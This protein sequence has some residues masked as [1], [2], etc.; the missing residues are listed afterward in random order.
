MF[1]FGLPHPVSPPTAPTDEN[2]IL[3]S[4]VVFETAKRLF[5]IT[6]CLFLMPLVA[7]LAAALLFLNPFLN[8]GPLL[9]AQERM[10]KNCKPFRVLKFRTMQPGACQRG[11]DDPVE[12]DRITFLGARLRVARLDELPQI[13]NVLRGEMSLIGP[14]PDC[15]DHAL[16]FLSK[17]PGYRDRHA[18]LPGISGYAQTQHGYAEGVEATTQKVAAD[19]HYISP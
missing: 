9:F 12:N 6:F 8:K 2:R 18:V 7:V 11:A 10:G 4:P 19:L 14:R 5:D 16:I 13:L 17:V 1:E 3:I 15:Y